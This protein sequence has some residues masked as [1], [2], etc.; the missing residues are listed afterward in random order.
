[1]SLI[2]LLQATSLIKFS[3]TKYP[4]LEILDEINFFFKIKKFFY[5][6]NNFHKNEITSFYNFRNNGI[7][8]HL[9]LIKHVFII[10]TNICVFK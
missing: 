2:M 1:M 6:I 9:L 7:K 8:I 10:I 5:R 3:K 4:F